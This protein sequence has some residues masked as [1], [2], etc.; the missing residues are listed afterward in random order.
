MPDIQHL[1]HALQRE[2]KVGKVA[3]DQAKQMHATTVKRKHNV[4]L[5]LG[6]LAHPSLPVEQASLFN[7]QN[8]WLCIQ[9]T[10]A[11]AI[12]T[13]RQECVCNSQQTSGWARLR[14]AMLE[15][16]MHDPTMLDQAHN[17]TQDARLHSRPNFER[18]S[19]QS[20]LHEN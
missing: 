5:Q 8:L 12:K 10:E 18:P 17:N 16:A 14:I 2:R 20:M 1:R 15:F 11:A 7:A 6:Y 13:P 19:Q 4:M 9:P 3:T